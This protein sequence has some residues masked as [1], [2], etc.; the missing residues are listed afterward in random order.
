M[1]DIRHAEA[2]MDSNDHVVKDTGKVNKKTKAMTAK[3]SP[4]R[5]FFARIFDMAIVFAALLPVCHYSGLLKWSVSNYLFI[6]FIYT[7]TFFV[8]DLVMN[9]AA[10]GTCGKLL[11]GLAVAGEKNSHLGIFKSFIRSLI[12]IVAGVGLLIPPVTVVTTVICFIMK[13]KGKTLPWEKKAPVYAHHITGLRVTWSA[14]LVVAIV[15]LGM[16]PSIISYLRLVPHSG[17]ITVDEFKEDYDVIEVKYLESL[18]DTGREYDPKFFESNKLYNSQDF[19]IATDENGVVKGFTYGDVVPFGKEYDANDRD[20]VVIGIS[21]LIASRKE[22][23]STYN[24]SLSTFS[25]IFE[26]P[27]DAHDITAGGVRVV[28]SCKKG[29]DGY[30]VIYEVSFAEEGSV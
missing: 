25:I 11:L 5:R 14:L 28:H 4:A 22:N 3:V 13:R 12:F 9:T 20:L 15:L 7:L 26:R 16:I 24:I 1:D 10:G 8:Y 21:T 30:V 27:F 6:Q 29:L 19:M 23:R 18:N 2:D 17:D